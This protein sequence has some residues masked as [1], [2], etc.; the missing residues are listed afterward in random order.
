[1]T[2]TQAVERLVRASVHLSDADLARPWAWKEYDEEGIRFALL[3]AHHELRDLAATLEDER[4]RGHAPLTLA[5]R[6]L[7]GY[8]ESYRDLTGALAGIR[9]EELD[10]APDEG[11]WPV[12]QVLQHM[13]GAESGF[14]TSMVLAL[15]IGRAGQRRSATDDEIDA[16]NVPEK[17]EG[18][19]RAVLDGL[20]R[21]HVR[22]LAE[23]GDVR[24]DELDT[25][26]EFWEATK[27]PVRFRMHRLEEHLRQHTVQ[28]DKT[29]AGIGHPPTEAERLVRLL[30]QAVGRVEA[31]QLGASE[32][33]QQAQQH[34]AEFIEGLARDVEAAL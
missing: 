16:L 18:D 4:A 2:P 22:V 24:D 31:A 15:R 33:A 29:L 3:M 34:S 13:L 7:G 32:V 11:E 30:Y 27:Y 25:P 12:R 28:V 10:R 9:D 14:R 5:Q 6:I 19:K 1:M 26:S 20:F 23:L 21:S 17:V 8:H